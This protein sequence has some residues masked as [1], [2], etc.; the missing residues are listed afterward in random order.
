[1]SRCSWDLLGFREFISQR[2]E[3][4]CTSYVGGQVILCWL[5]KDNSLLSIYRKIK[6]RDGFA[7]KPAS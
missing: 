5:H 7:D 3:L 1:M 4:S 2:V 6:S